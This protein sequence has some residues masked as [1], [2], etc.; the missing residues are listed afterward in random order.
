[1]KKSFIH[2]II[3]IGLIPACNKHAVTPIPG[4]APY[5]KLYQWLAEESSDLKGADLSINRELQ[6]DQN[7]GVSPTDSSNWEDWFKPLAECD[8]SKPAYHGFYQVDSVSKGNTLQLTY[9]ALK[10]DAVVRELKVTLIN[11]RVKAVSAQKEV[12]N[13]LYRSKATIS[14]WKDSLY[15]VDY[16]QQTKFFKD[17]RFK[18]SYHLSKKQ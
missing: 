9:S 7:V 2:F 17:H 15:V 13:L 5:F 18:A 1:M 8:L 3:V 12:N 14:Y 6:T 4:Q 16:L 11:G 10:P